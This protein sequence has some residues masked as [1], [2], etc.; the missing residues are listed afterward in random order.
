MP[1]RR[2]HEIVAGMVRRLLAEG[3]DFSALTGDEWRAASELFDVDVQKAATAW[4]SVERRQTPQSTGPE[5]VRSAL[6]DCRAWVE[7]LGR[8]TER[9][10]H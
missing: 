5:A 4:A 9:V 7:S 2:A 1:F 8:P 6:E 3:R 10:D